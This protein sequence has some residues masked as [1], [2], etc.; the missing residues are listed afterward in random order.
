MIQ[1]MATNVKEWMSRNAFGVS[2]YSAS[3]L[4]FTQ[5]NLKPLTPKL[6]TIVGTIGNINIV[7]AMLIAAITLVIK[8]VELYR[9]V[10]PKKDCHDDAEKEET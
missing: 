8:G 2:G 5:V 10:K 7:L 9:T 3:S 6:A 4:V 1:T